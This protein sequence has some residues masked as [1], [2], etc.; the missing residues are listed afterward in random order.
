[1]KEEEEE[2]NAQC[3]MIEIYLIESS[4]NRKCQDLITHFAFF[5]S[6]KHKHIYLYRRCLRDK[7]DEN[8]QIEGDWG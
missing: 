4:L 2:T 1:M 6:F 8:N 7:F 5:S 3:W